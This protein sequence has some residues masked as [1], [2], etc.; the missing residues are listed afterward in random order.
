MP[1]T[2]VQPVYGLQFGV[3]TSGRTGTATT[4]VSDATALSIAI[5]GKVEEWSPL[6]SEG[7]TRR[8]MTGKSITV[9]MGGKRNYGDAGNDYIASL[10]FRNGRDCE[11]VFS[12]IFPDGGRLSFNCVINVTALGGESTAVS[13]LS[14]TVLSDG[15]PTY[16]A[17]GAETS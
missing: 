14:W 10:A 8:L 5:D 7:W 1:A 3:N 15:K 4:T 16:T 12:I 6:D 17:A 11:S 2:G 9:T 13:E